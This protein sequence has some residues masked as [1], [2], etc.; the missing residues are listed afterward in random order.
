[1]RLQRSDACYA[2][3]RII[4][5]SCMNI[6]ILLGKIEK[7]F[8]LV[9]RSDSSLAQYWLTDQKGMAGTITDAEWESAK[10]TR[11]DSKWQDV[12]IKELEEYGP[13]LAHM[14]AKDFRYFLPA[15]MQVALKNIDV[16]PTWDQEILGG[17]VFSLSPSKKELSS[18]LYNVDQLSMLNEEQEETIIEFLEFVSENADEFERPYAEKA[19]RYWYERRN[20]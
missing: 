2:R 19:L 5:V 4:G 11:P 16:K 1:M 8:N 18:Y 12:P 13:L 15:Y 7:A 3:A 17:T 6:E 9:Q 14:N 10:R 20:N